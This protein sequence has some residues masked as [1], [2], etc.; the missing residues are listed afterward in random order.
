MY[1]IHIKNSVR[2]LRIKRFSCE[3]H[4]FC[5]WLKHIKLTCLGAVPRMR[6]KYRR[7]SDGKLFEHVNT[8]I[9]R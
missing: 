9:V 2:R 6:R 7:T 3:R 8:N 4:G 5:L 1:G